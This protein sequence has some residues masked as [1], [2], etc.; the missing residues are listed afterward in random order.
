M[1]GEMGAR[2]APEGKI[3]DEERE[4]WKTGSAKQNQES[5]V[6][7]GRDGGFLRL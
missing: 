1:V 7:M 3:R 5:T 6:P 2:K 4:V